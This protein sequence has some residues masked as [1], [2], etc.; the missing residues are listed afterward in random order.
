MR[1]PFFS[2]ELG[3]GVIANNITKPTRRLTALPA[4]PNNLIAYYL[5]AYPFCHASP[6][7]Q[8]LEQGPLIHTQ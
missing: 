8:I 2:L 1:N 7:N 3:V 4:S 5:T 6:A